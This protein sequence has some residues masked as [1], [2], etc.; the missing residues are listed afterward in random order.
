MEKHLALTQN[1]SDESQESCLEERGEK[2]GP[3]DKYSSQDHMHH[4]IH[5]WNFHPITSSHR[6]LRSQDL[7]H[8]ER[9]QHANIPLTPTSEVFLG[10]ICSHI[11]YFFRG[12]E[13]LSSPSTLGT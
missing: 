12:G 5:T 13:G 7:E 9:T 6:M 3:S 8:R 11:H 1:N 4:E 10:V 2:K